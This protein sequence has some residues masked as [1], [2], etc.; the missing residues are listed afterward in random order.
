MLTTGFINALFSDD[1]KDTIQQTIW[2]ETEAKIRSD[3]LASGTNI[4]V[5]KEVVWRYFR[6]DCAARL[7]IVL[8]MNPEG[9]TLRKRCRSFPGC[10][11]VFASSLKTIVR[12]RD[13]TLADSSQSRRL[14]IL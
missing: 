7:H 12:G 3:A 10:V 1:E 2:A 11:A 4:T 9:D 14:Q 13:E 5:T 6:A 8:C